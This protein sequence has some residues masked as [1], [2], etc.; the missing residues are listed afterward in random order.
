MGE[1]MITYAEQNQTSTCS[2]AAH[3]FD[4][5]WAGICQ[6]T[7]GKGTLQILNGSAQIS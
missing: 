3:H 6:K 7:Q 1:R 4:K 5:L 2:I